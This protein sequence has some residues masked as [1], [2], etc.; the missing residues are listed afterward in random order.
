MHTLA[1]LESGELKGVNHLQIAENLTVFP[2]SIFTLADTLEVL[3]LSNNQLSSLPDDFDQ[4]TQLKI[5]FLSQNQFRSLPTVLGRCPKLEMIGFKANQLS[6]LA[7]NALPKQTRW[8]IL[9]DNQL[10]QL[11]DS[12][13]DLTQLKK[14]ALAGNKLTCLPSSMA[15]CRELELLR[16]SANQ[17]TALP[18]WL[19]T[20][21]KLAWL[22]FAGNHFSHVDV[23]QNNTVPMLDLEHIDLIEP[24]G[25]GASGVI[26]RAAWHKQPSGFPAMTAVKIFKGAIT[27]DG[28]PA[29]ELDC[30][31]T[32]GLHSNLIKVIG[33]INQAG[34]LGLVMELIPAG[35]SNL[36][37]PPS[38]ATCT[39][40]IFADGTRFGINAILTIALQMSETLHHMHQQHIS[41]GDI[42][43]H[44]IMVN[45]QNDVLF[46]DFGAASNLARLNAFQ[47]QMIAQIEVRAFGCLL[48]D[49]L[50]QLEPVENAQD[51]ALMANLT[52]LSSQ[53]MSLDITHRPSFAEITQA[54]TKR[55]S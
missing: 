35:F 47:Q 15:N 16:L 9:T 24:I 13:G 8:L 20:L 44:N 4:L 39:R 28:Y 7:P 3:D 33:Q 26:Y 25:Q 17:L 46:G 48:D 34:Q 19:V 51:K 10:T 11:P 27:S 40:D 5:L 30:C 50:Q 1:Q 36:G 38:L 54:L 53:C 18:D 49:L 32:T 22:A 29:D 12:M 31:L 43:A 14:L 41:H 55:L 52:Q 37:L 45:Q 23:C 2:R 6:E 21:P 42:Y